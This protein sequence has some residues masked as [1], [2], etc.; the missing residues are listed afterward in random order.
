[1]SVRKNDENVEDLDKDDYYSIAVTKYML[2]IGFNGVGM[3]P[4][5]PKF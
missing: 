1:M 2:Y 5:C 3:N 4:E